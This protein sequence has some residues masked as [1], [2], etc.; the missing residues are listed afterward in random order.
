MN[1][2]ILTLGGVPFQNYEVP[3]KIRFGGAQRLAVHELIGGGRVVDVLGNADG[4]ILFSGVFSGADAAARAQ[5]LDAARALG[6][7]IPLIWDSFFYTVVLAEFAAEYSKPWWIPFAVR[8]VVVNDPIAEIAS[9]AAPVANLISNDILTATSLGPLAG[10]SL[11][12]LAFP[13]AAGF[14][15]AQAQIT[16]DITSAGLSLGSNTS[17]LNE[18]PDATTGIDTMNELVAN[19]GQLAALSSLRGYVNRAAANFTDELT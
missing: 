9:V 4:E 6:A 15:A 11:G 18:A 2:V 8:C 12:G 1:K 14:A 16:S 17:A 5:V 3:E 19:V 10:L 13:S 7:A